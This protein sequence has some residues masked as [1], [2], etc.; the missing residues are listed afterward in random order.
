MEPT[1]V[2]ESSY[3]V[4]GKLKRMAHNWLETMLNNSWS[5]VFISEKGALAYTWSPGKWGLKDDLMKSSMWNLLKCLVWVSTSKIL[6][7]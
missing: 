6:D 2:N 4:E 5:C 3:K 1:R 7:Y